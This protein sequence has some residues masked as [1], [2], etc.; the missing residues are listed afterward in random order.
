MKHLVKALCGFAVT[1]I[2]FPVA[3]AEP[4]ASEFP[5]GGNS[6]I[7]LYTVELAGPTVLPVQQVSNFRILVRNLSDCP[8]V[9]L[10]IFSNIPDIGTVSASPGANFSF[11]GERDIF[12]WTSLEAP[13]RGHASILHL[14]VPLATS[15][16][17]Y[18][19]RVC[20]TSVNG[21]PACSDHRFKV[22]SQTLLEE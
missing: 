1:F 19:A 22:V 10:T 3:F 13:P 15:V 20:V 2:L 5:P 8:I 16:G 6:C 9:N 17:D 21:I 4:T 11:I 14:L 7:P 18:V 12:V